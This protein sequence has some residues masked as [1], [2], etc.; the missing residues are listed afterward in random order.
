MLEV[1]SE[2]TKEVDDMVTSLEK[3]KTELDKKF[4]SIMEEFVSSAFENFYNV[5]EFDTR[6]NFDHWIR[7]TCNDIVMGLLSGDTKWL[8]HQAIISE[9]SWD[10]LRAV[11]LAILKAAQGEIENSVILSLQKDVE[12]LEKEN[13]NLRRS[14]NY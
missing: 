8:K 4:R 1:N 9:Y 12:R 14:R 6:Y 2:I 3:A 11:R 7:R 13:Q 10:K 5:I